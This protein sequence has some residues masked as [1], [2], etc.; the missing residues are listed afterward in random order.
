L[1]LN[2][3]IRNIQGKNPYFVELIKTPSMKGITIIHDE[4]NN[5]R[6]VQID[7]RYLNEHPDEVE[8]M[9]D[10]IVAEMRKDEETVDWKTVKEE[11]RKKGKL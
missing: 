11:L 4:T 2:P 10:A 8:E 6:F 5:K 3:L 7:T 1:R 9:L